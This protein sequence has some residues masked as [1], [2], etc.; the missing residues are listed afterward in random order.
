MKKILSYIMVLVMVFAVSCSSRTSVPQDAEKSEAPAEEEKILKTEET[1][2]QEDDPNKIASPLDGLKYYPEELSKR[3]VALSLD[4]HPDARWQS[5]LKDAE[6]VYEFEVE[7]PYTR[8]LAVYLAKEPELVG[9]VRSARPYIIYYAMENDAVFVHV[10]GS[11]EAFSEI[12]RLGTAEVDGLYSGAMWRYNDTGKFAPHNMYTTLQSIRDES[13]RLGFRSDASFEK[14]D[15]NDK[16]VSLSKKYDSVNAKKINIAYNKENTTEYVYDDESGL[17][18]R[19]KDNE[20]H[21]DE[22]DK[23]QLETK[24]IIVLEAPKSVLDSEGR[25]KLKTIGTGEGMYFTNGEF[26]N[27]TWKKD[28][29]KERTRFYIDGEQLKFNPGNTWIQIVDSVSCVAAE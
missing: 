27:I 3:P 8:Y 13:E 17:Y 1:E 18:L 16:S 5:G 24:N 26:V 9:P 22:L 12:R 25:L 14:Y 11:E 7:Y 19:F 29:E 21:L 10:G 15:F 20:K 28:S 4:N 23:E 2:K 6:I